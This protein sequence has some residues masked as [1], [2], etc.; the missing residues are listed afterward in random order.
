MAQD[1]PGAYAQSIANKHYVQAARFLVPAALCGLALIAAL[2]V[3][4]PLLVQGTCLIVLVLLAAVAQPDLQA[5]A[6]AAAGARA[7][8]R[9]A[10][11][12][13]RRFSL[14][15]SGLL[16]PGYRGD[17]DFVVGDQTLAIVEVKGAGQSGPVYANGDGR[18]SGRRGVLLGGKDIR[19]QALKEAKAVSMATGCPTFAVICLT[20]ATSAPDTSW[21][22]VVVCGVQDLEWVLSSGLPK[23]AGL[24]LAKVAAGLEVAE[25]ERARSDA[26]QV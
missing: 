24:D 14:V 1:R 9:V 18:I 11:L 26:S 15:R 12:L 20:N 16:L 13:Y 6:R 5:A 17:I 3:Q 8:R 7:E 19:R 23:V 22:N 2:W 21:G 10:T 25:A 4:A